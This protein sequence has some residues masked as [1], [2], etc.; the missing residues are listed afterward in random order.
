MGCTASGQEQII[1]EPIPDR[2]ERDRKY[3]R[4][5]SHGADELSPDPSL[6]EGFRPNQQIAWIIDDAVPKVRGQKKKSKSTIDLNQAESGEMPFADRKDRPAASA[7][8]KELRE[9]LNYDFGFS[10]VQ[11]SVFAS[12]NELHITQSIICKRIAKATKQDKKTLLFVYYRGGGGLDMR[13][14]DTYAILQNGKAFA[15]EHFLRDLAQIKNCY[16]MGVLDCP[17]LRLQY[18][19]ED[20]YNSKDE[21]VRNLILMFGCKMLQDL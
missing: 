5:S 9:M 1:Q 20:D 11:E 10:H 7:W 18:Q 3:T 19:I 15:I 17:R 6:S 16:V 12:I 4:F 14:L 8:V 21:G 13:C 2:P